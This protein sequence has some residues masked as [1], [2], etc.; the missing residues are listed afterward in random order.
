MAWNSGSY[1]HLLSYLASFDSPPAGNWGEGGAV[2]QGLTAR[3]GRGPDSPLGL[4]GMRAL[5]WDG[6]MMS[7]LL[8]DRAGNSGSSIGLS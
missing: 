7:S 3:E 4:H 2:R 1:L 5:E 6:K 8:L